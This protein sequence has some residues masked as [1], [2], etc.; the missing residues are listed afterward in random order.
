M[1]TRL[2]W[3]EDPRNY[4]PTVEGQ[5]ATEAIVEAEVTNCYRC[6]ADPRESGRG[7]I[8]DGTVVNG[9]LTGKLLCGTCIDELPD[10]PELEEIP[11]A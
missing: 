3:T 1:K 8:M 5:P 6:G 10:P 2:K 4:Q 7:I 11:D 9:V